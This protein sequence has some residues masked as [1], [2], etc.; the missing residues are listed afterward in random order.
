MI[1]LF[2]II[3]DQILSG[4][5]SYLLLWMIIVFLLVDPFLNGA[6]NNTK[7]AEK[8]A[9]RGSHAIRIIIHTIVGIVFLILV[10]ALIIIFGLLFSRFFML[11][12]V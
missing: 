1:G 9:K 5:E 12:F 11:I 6:L 2:Q 10:I 7:Y 4:N 8:L 3:I